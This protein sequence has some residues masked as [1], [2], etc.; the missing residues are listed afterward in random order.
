MNK[1][2]LLL[3]SCTFLLCSFAHAEDQKCHLDSDCEALGK[4][5]VCASENVACPSQ[6]SLS[7]CMKQVCRPKSIPQ[8][9]RMCKTNADCALLITSCSCI[10]NSTCSKATDNADG[11]LTSVNKKFSDRYSDLS[12]CTESESKSCASA[13]ACASQGTWA[14]QCLQNK[15]EVVFKAKTK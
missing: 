9:H 5:M 1:V 15:C 14:T 12:K 13:G 11:F 4:N 6:P 7:K 8:L 3:I 10:H 2:K